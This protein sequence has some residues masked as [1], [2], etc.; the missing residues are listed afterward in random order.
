MIQGTQLFILVHEYTRLHLYCVLYSSGR[1]LLAAAV[2]THGPQWHF[3]TS[4]LGCRWLQIQQYSSSS[5]STRTG[6]LLC[7]R[8]HIIAEFCVPLFALLSQ[9]SPAL[10]SPPSFCLVQYW[11]ELLLYHNVIP[12]STSSFCSLLPLVSLSLSHTHITTNHTCRESPRTCG[13]HTEWGLPLE[14]S[15]LQLVLHCSRAAVAVAQRLLR[16]DLAVMV[17][18]WASCGRGPG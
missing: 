17:L 13:V 4:S 1:V 9:P 16:Q 7:T 15:S 12:R 18:S 14:Q 11:L 10:P 5:T 2:D 3:E 6:L 8:R